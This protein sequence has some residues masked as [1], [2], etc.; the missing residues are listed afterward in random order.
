MKIFHDA[1][2]PSIYASSIAVVDG[3]E[4]NFQCG[5]FLYRAKIYSISFDE[6]RSALILRGDIRRGTTDP[7][8]PFTAEFQDRKQCYHITIED[9]SEESPQRQETLPCAR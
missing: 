9:D 1:E 2:G 3:D 6:K 4:K 5:D 8:L 7:F